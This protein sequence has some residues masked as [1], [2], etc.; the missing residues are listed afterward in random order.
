[1]TDTVD[2]VVIGSGHN[3]LVAAAYLARAGMSVEV[4][5]RNPMAGGAVA[6]E[7][8][9]DPGYTHDTFSSW[10]PL[11]KLSA[12]YAELGPEL[13]ER[14]LTY[15]ETPEAT[16]ANVRPDGTVA[17]AY[18]EVERTTES[19]APADRAPY[20][21][22]IE[23]F[24]STI[25]TVGQLLGTEL[26][27][28]ASAKLTWQLARQLGRRRGLRFT[29]DLL[30][31]ARAWLEAHF[32]GREVADLYAPWALHT[33]LSPDAAGSGFQALAIA[34]SLH[35]V[36]LPV[37]QGGAGNF[38][39]AFER[40]IAA[41][42]G[43][44]TTGTE[45]ER[46][47]TRGH[48]A[49][50]VH[51]G[52]REIRARR[53]VIANTTPSQLY[54]R[55]LAPGAAPSQAVEQ[56][57]RFRYS[58]RGGMQIHVALTERLRWRDSRL[59]GVPLVHLSDGLSSVALACAQAAAGLLPAR[60]TVVAGQPTVVDPSRAPDGRAVLWVQLQ[61]VPYAPAGDAAGE[62]DSGD[63][64]WTPELERD[65]TERVL[66]RVGE[67]VE[68]WPQARGTAAGLTPAEMERRNPNLVRGDIY[69]GDCELG[70]SYLWRPL[71]SYGT[72]ATP[73]RDLYQCGA[74]T[75]PGPGLN[76]A[77]GRIVALRIIAGSGRLGTA[78]RLLRA[79][80]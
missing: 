62:I 34:G 80:R 54:G 29:A 44:V 24:G 41:H 75:Y 2:V 50:G 36:G 15:C 27:S 10:H 72:H 46:I 35:A 56:A 1:M 38:V 78:A 70:Q 8:L 28:G 77:S 18:R 61:Q 39:R 7:E 65:F 71:P 6:S 20:T 22:E 64:A 45:V 74:S 3:G 11:F 59:N 63:G 67:H 43:T 30:S 9:T 32:G 19:F 33:G 58:P 79:G 25:P 23:R 16:T 4:L 47:L 42:G 66:G 26:F 69:A 49:V 60:P 13:H 17:I 21:A 14:G 31:S 40:L 57:R 37:V 68:N 52:G 12:A 76:A 53:A 73:V 51:A 5:E 48:R 55:L